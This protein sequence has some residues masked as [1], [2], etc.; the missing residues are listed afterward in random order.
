MLLSGIISASWLLIGYIHCLGSHTWVFYGISVPCT[1]VPLMTQNSPTVQLHPDIV[2]LNVKK[3]E[4]SHT[5]GPFTSPPLPNFQSSPIWLR[6]KQ[7]WQIQNTAQYIY[8]L[9]MKFQSIAIFPMKLPISN[10]KLYW[11]IFIRFN[12]TPPAPIQLSLTS[13]MP[14]ISSLSTP[15]SFDHFPGFSFQDKFYYDTTLIIGAATSC[16]VQQNLTWR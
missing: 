14:S 6:P 12:F 10:N 4:L 2:A 11:A 3:L 8:P 7:T 15:P 5:V 13:H 16:I 9:K 1:E